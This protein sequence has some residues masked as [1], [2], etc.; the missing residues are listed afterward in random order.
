MINKD[1]VR[2]FGEQPLAKVMSKHGLKPHDI[3]SALAQQLSHKMIARAVKGRRLTP[4]V[5]TK[6][7][8]GLNKAAGSV[9]SMAELFNY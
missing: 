8:K 4:N 9:Y 6:I 5:K 7:L 1:I 3:V 2:D